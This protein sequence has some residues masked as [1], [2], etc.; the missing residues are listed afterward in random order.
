MRSPFA[1]EGTRA[2]PYSERQI[3]LYVIDFKLLRFFLSV[4]DRLRDMFL[5]GNLCR[6]GTR[7]GAHGVEIGGFRYTWKAAPSGGFR[8]LV[9]VRQPLRQIAASF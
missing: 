6:F 8:N 3:R 4:C 7:S 1:H 2:T 9:H 5:I